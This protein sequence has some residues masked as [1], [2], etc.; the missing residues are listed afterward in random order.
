MLVAKYVVALPTLYVTLL[1][2]DQLATTCMTK[3]PLAYIM[4]VIRMMV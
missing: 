4:R 1:I 3:S 2:K